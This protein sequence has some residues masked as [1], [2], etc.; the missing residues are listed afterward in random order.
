[1]GIPSFTS[2]HMEQLKD[3]LDKG[4]KIGIPRGMDN[5]FIWW[6]PWEEVAA[7]MLESTG[8]SLDQLCRGDSSKEKKEMENLIGKRVKINKQAMMGG[9]EGKVV[10]VVS[11]SDDRFVVTVQFPDGGTHKYAQPCSLDIIPD[12]IYFCFRCNQSSKTEYHR[13]PARDPLSSGMNLADL[14]PHKDAL[15][16]ALGV[17]DGK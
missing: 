3:M 1:M 10:G 15:L 11:R 14:V 17:K 13:C 6:D 2:K 16:K 5:P 4:R 12:P 8:K 7:E 9:K